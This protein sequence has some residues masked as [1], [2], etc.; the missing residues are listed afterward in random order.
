MWQ[1]Q[2]QKETIYFYS[3]LQIFGTSTG[4]ADTKLD[5]SRLTLGS[6]WGLFKKVHFC[7]H[8]SLLKAE[9]LPRKKKKQLVISKNIKSNK[10][11]ISLDIK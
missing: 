5:Y 2:K 6:R 11:L 3:P 4:S 9:N 8:G 10:K 1:E 7:N